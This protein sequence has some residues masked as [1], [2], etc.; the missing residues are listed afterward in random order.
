MR[1]SEPGP[2]S[3]VLSRLPPRICVLQRK[4]VEEN[5]WREQHFLGMSPTGTAPTPAVPTHPSTHLTYLH[6]SSLHSAQN[7]GGERAARAAIP[8]HV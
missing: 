1:G 4:M 6:T 7:G 5:E 2:P 8:G 3:S